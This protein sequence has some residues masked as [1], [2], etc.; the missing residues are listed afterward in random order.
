[1][2]VRHATTVGR[3]RVPGRG[4]ARRLVPALALCVTLLG[5]GACGG[6]GD[7]GKDGTTNPT[8]SSGTKG[9]KGGTDGGAPKQSTA[10]LNVE[11]ADGAVDV[12]TDGALKVGVAGGK[13]TEVSVKAQGAEAVKGEISADGAT[14]QPDA[15][16]RTGTKY[17][18]SATGTDDGGLSAAL[19]SSFTTLSPENVNY[20]VF[21]IDANATYGIGMIVSLEFNKPVANKD[22]ADE[23]ITVTSDPPVDVKGHWFGNQRL[24]FRPEEYWEPGTKV[25]LHLDLDG[26]QLSPN[27]YG[28]Q[29]KDV[30]FKIGRAQT[31]VADND[32]HTLTVTRDG[33]VF[34]TLPAT[35]GD[36][37]HTTYNGK[38]L[39][40]S[41][42]P[43]V[44]MDSQSVGLGTAYNIPD[45]PHGMRLSTS[46]TYAHGNYWNHS[47]PF[48]NSNT[49]HGCV[50]LEDVKGGGD[51]SMPAA[52]F[53][54]NS[55]IGDV[56]EVVHSDTMIDPDNGWSGW[57]MTWSAW[58]V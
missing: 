34:K 13:L 48:G 44:A 28:K 14:W 54:D 15:P 52:W 32:E 56:L 17:A 7:G 27:V 29:K 33:A 10:V 40:M 3:N 39:I 19:H 5:V 16:L 47:D 24:D 37:E 53:Y 6:G 26:K 55:L 35:L 8:A 9:G 4:R 30:S 51:P 49:S 1:M 41:K 58:N 2:S 12:A 38:M 22:V 43:L 25:T 23:G 18:V 11:P 21:N 20:G 42:E 57:N 46:G 36:P 50:S 31:S 45:V